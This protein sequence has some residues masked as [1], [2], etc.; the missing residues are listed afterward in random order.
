MGMSTPGVVSTILARAATL[1]R[2]RVAGKDTFL[3]QRPDDTR[4]Y[5]LAEG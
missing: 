1:T 5:D 3:A 2:R 4:R